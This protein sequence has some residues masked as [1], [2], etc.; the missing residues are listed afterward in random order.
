MNNILLK[1][2][3]THPD[4]V[5]PKQGS[6]E[7][8]GLDIFATEE[9]IIPAKK[10]AQVP[11]GLQLADCPKGCWIEIRIR[12]SKGIKGLAVLA[13]TIDSDYRGDMGAFIYNTGDEDFVI[14]KGERFA[15]L[16]PH[17]LP[18]NVSVEWGEVTETERGQ[19]GFGSTGKF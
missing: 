16:V 18:E 2:K 15:Q 7:A 6:K 8:A 13:G 9:T 1:F 10:Q 19:G 17:M 5:L 12:S 4:A 11:I 14:E 3:K